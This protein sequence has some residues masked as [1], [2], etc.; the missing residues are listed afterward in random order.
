MLFR[1]HTGSF[2]KGSTGNHYTVTVTNSGVGDKAAATL[3]TMTET[4]PSG[5]TVTAMSGGGWTCNLA[6]CTR[7]DVLLAGASYPTIDVTVSIS[8]SATSPIVN[9][10]AVTTA[11]AETNTGNNSANDSTTLT[12][13]NLGIGK[14]H[15]GS[16]VAGSTGNT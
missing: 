12:A 14:S 8:L 2:V 7:S 9:A 16:F 4:A 13:V 6:T 3:V 1:S 15:T 5:M 10:V 11:S